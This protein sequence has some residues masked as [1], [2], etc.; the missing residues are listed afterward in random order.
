MDDEREFLEWNLKVRL[1]ITRDEAGRLIM[2]GRFGWVPI[3]ENL[4]GLCVWCGAYYDD[5]GT[6][7]PGTSSEHREEARR[8]LGCKGGDDGN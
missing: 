7:C 1:G 6:D 2:P 3:N 8:I 5:C 4:D